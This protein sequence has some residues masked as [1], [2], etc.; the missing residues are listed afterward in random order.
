MPVFSKV[1]AASI[2]GAIVTLIVTLASAV[3]GFEIPA[4]VAA[5]MVTIIGF[6]VGFFKLERVGGYNPGG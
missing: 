4:E 3:W 5:A 2:A 1:K 6:V